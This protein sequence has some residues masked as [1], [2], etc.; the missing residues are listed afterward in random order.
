MPNNKEYKIGD[1]N[2]S[3]VKSGAMRRGPGGHGPAMA[4]GE[5]AKDFSGSIKRLA[6]YCKKYLPGIFIAIIFVTASTV[7]NLIGPNKFSEITD[8]IIAGI[9]TGIDVNAAETIA[10]TLAAIYLFSYIFNAAQGYIMASISQKI[11]RSL[12]KEISE[13]INRLPLKY[14]DKT[15]TGDVL[16]RVTNDVDMIGQTLNQSL[17]NLVLSFATLVGA[18]FMMYKTNWMLASSTI[19]ATAVGFS[20]MMF[21]IKKSQKYFMQQQKE[22]GQLN[23]H[24]E[25]IYAGHNVV[26]AYNGE[27]EASKIF[28]EMNTRL[29]DCAWKSRF[30]SGLMMPI[31]GF[32]GNLGYVV[33]CVLGA[34]LAKNGTITFGVIVAF[35]LYVRLFTQPLAQIAQAA[36]SLQ[37]T[38]AASERVFEFSD[39]EEMEKDHIGEL[40]MAEVKGNVE[41]DKVHFGY[42][43]NKIII[44]DFSLSAKEGQKIAI[45]GPTGAGK[46]TMV[47]L[48]MRFY[49]LNSGNI[50]IDGVSSKELSREQIHSLFGMVLQDTWIFEGSIRENIIYSKQNATEEDVINACKAVGLHH[51]INTLQ[52][53][54]DTLLNDNANLSAGQKQLITIARAMIENAPM[55]ILDE[56]TSSVDTRTE[57]LIQKA[58]DRLMKGR[59]SFVIAHRLST[60]KNADSILVMNEGDVIESGTH[61]EL[62]AKDGFYANLYNSQFEQVS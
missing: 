57:V 18:L 36:A 9:Q 15:S 62:L 28:G 35:M 24:I 58:M 16:S 29:Y 43:D 19:L 49:E 20:L 4:T 27:K 11:T 21:I 52:N 56:A 39:E 3:Q 59:T 54:Y 14:F 26:K 37:S 2:T 5:K 23:G 45:V 40:N 17:G 44:N 10:Y 1:A 30:M 38:A 55:L 12:R 31:M 48:L 25:E 6:G 61:E 34:V 47:N 22:L 42:D 60:I 46:T 50:Y 7:L 13:K 51:F 32:V 53:G 8:I 41:F 33:V